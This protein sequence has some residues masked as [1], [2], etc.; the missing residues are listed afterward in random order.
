MILIS[1]HLQQIQ[2]RVLKNLGSKCVIFAT[3]TAFLVTWSMSWNRWIPRA[4]VRITAPFGATLPCPSLHTHSAAYTGIKSQLLTLACDWSCQFY[5]IMNYYIFCG[6]LPKTS[7]CGKNK[8][9]KT[10]NF[11]DQDTFYK[12]RLVIIL[13]MNCYFFSLWTSVATVSS[14]GS[15]HISS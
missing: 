15:I 11:F 6:I 7:V 2:K 12:P 3:S 10:S 1:F 4:L 8:K 5:K 9:M 14:F 13:F